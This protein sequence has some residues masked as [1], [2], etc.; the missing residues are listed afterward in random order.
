[1][2]EIVVSAHRD[3]DLL[4]LSVHAWSRVELDVAA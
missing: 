2:L 3:V 4:R 1:M